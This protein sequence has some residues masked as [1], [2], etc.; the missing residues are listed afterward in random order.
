MNISRP[1]PGVPR[2]GGRRHA[3]PQPRNPAVTQ[4]P[5]TYQAI[6]SGTDLIANAIRP[7]LGP[8][9]RLVVLEGLRSHDVPEF[10]DD[11]ATIA[12]R[13]IEVKPRTT[14]VGAMMIRH[15]L[16][17]MHQEAGD[18]AATMAVMYQS[19]VQEGIRW[20]TQFDCNAMLLRAGLEKGARAI[21]SCLRQQAFPLAGRRSIAN[22]ARGMCQGD[23]KLADVLGEIFDMVGTDG[24][25]VV[26]GY[27]KLGLEREY[28]EG[29]Y[30]KLSGWFS[31]HFVT[32]PESRRTTFEDAALL[33]TDFNIQDPHVLVPP[34]EKCIRAGVKQLV[35]V[36][37]DISDAAIGLLV[38]NNQAKTIQCMAVR[39]PKVM[40]M[41]R[42]AAIG[43]IAVLTGGNPI[44]SAAFR[45]LEDVGVADLG[46]ARRAWATESMFGIYGGKGDPRQIRRRVNELR[47]QM[48]QVDLEHDKG[49]LRA[50]IG[51][52]NGGTVILRLGAIHD[53]ERTQRKSVAERAVTGIRHA[54][55]GG[56]V[57]GGGA[58][59]LGACSALAELPAANEEERIAYRILARALEEPLRT[60]AHN[61]GHIPDVIVERLRHVPQGSGFDARSGQIVDMRQ[62]GIL[63]AAVVLQRAVDIAI[64]GAAMALTTDVLIHH[65]WPKETVEP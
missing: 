20:I 52:L 61:A 31:R 57:P 32:E 38:N 62:A 45:S 27:E 15:A 19:I 29:T 10:L 17:Q 56:V 2:D 24:L 23:D 60:I 58:A 59:L 65:V 26:E 64:S 47:G 6:Q 34:L 54:I 55:D 3:L 51:R 16:W 1:I 33:I 22:I 42:V 49:D 43:D 63:D 4:Q 12:R 40:E 9:P 30:W 13:I 37:S 53:T 39:V 8:L 28:I 46:H 21:Q 14:D 11:A 50:R 44:F 18:G 35:I 41:D 7:T 36:A 5:K 25:I 48:A